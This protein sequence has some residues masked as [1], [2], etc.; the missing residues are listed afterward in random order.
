LNSKIEET[1]KL[2]EYNDHLI[3][4]LAET[5]CVHTENDE[6][7]YELEDKKWCQIV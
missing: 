6:V 1:K 2:D 7:K 4:L 5:R 3:K